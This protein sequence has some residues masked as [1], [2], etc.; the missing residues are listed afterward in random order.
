MDSLFSGLAAAI[1]AGVAG[2]AF[3]A[4]AGKALA[5]LLTRALGRLL[6]PNHPV[7]DERDLIP[8]R[9]GSESERE[10]SGR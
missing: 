2:S 10:T 9:L 4:A 7:A 3:G 8:V 6:D 5:G 1:V